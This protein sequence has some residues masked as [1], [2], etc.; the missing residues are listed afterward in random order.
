M[1]ISSIAKRV[2]KQVV[3]PVKKK[4]DDV[5]KEVQ[6]INE[7]VKCPTSVTSNFP[8]C[9]KN[10]LLDMLGYVIYVIVI[11]VRLPW[12]V[13]LNIVI[14]FLN[15]A[16]MPSVRTIVNFV[17]E[18]LMQP[19]WAIKGS[20]NIPYI[21]LWINHKNDVIRYVNIV[22]PF[23]D[24]TPVMSK[25]YCA[26][27]IKWVFQP[28]QDKSLSWTEWANQLFKPVIVLFHWMYAAYAAMLG[29]PNDKKSDSSV[30]IVSIGLLLIGLL[31]FV[32]V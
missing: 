4:V 10:Y 15:W 6:Q 13:L 18:L 20:I 2:A 27:S 25:C 30:Y 1:G 22:F 24:R 3:A 17:T 7:M 9:G 31:F 11:I 19:K 23:F 5:A 32:W 8:L 14:F 16:I 29:D 12:V 28:L 26:D 21:Q